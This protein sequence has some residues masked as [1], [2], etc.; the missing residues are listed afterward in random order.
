MYAYSLDYCHIIVCGSRR[1]QPLFTIITQLLYGT[2]LIITTD[3]VLNF[4]AGKA[5]TCLKWDI[6]I[7]I[8]Y[9]SIHIYIIINLFI[10]QT[11]SPVVFAYRHAVAEQQNV[12]FTIRMSDVYDCTLG[13]GTL[14]LLCYSHV[15]T[16]FTYYSFIHT[17]YAH[18][19][20]LL[21]LLNTFIAHIYNQEFLLYCSITEVIF[22]KVWQS[23]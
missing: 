3:S 13:L 15:L 17:N 21:C 16:S 23:V 19:I 18:T 8:I 12:L 10:V 5:N 11:W 20:N 14:C 2:H 7:L 1:D 9:G 4:P 6:C 22:Q